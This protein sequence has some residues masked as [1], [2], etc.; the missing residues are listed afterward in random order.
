MISTCSSFVFAD[1]SALKGGQTCAGSLTV[2]LSLFLNKS[3]IS[4]TICNS[5]LGVWHYCLLL[6]SNYILCFPNF[7]LSQF[8]HILCCEF[9]AVNEITL[10]CFYKFYQSLVAISHLHHL[11]LLSISPFI[12]CVM[13]V[14]S[15][16][17]NISFFTNHSMI[18]SAFIYHHSFMCLSNPL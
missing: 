16:N 3:S 17:Q 1:T 11:L 12:Y 6:I 2:L 8:S 4:M 14:V 9:D 18:F 7:W 13:C 15:S 10:E 5:K